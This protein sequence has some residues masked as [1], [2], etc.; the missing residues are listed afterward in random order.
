MF[1][2]GRLRLTGD[3]GVSPGELILCL[4]A[5]STKVDHMYGIR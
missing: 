1:R 4:Q 2:E 3:I 5:N